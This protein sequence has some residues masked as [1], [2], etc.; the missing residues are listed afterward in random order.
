MNRFKYVLIAVLVLSIAGISWVFFSRSDSLD[1]RFSK[2]LIEYDSIK[3]LKPRLTNK[4]SYYECWAETAKDRL[5]KEQKQYFISYMA[6]N[7]VPKGSEQRKRQIISLTLLQSVSSCEQKYFVDQRTPESLTKKAIGDLTAGSETVRKIGFPEFG[8]VQIDVEALGT[9]DADRLYIEGPLKSDSYSF[10]VALLSVDEIYETEYETQ[11]KIVVVLQTRSQT[12][13]YFEKIFSTGTSEYAFTDVAEN[14]TC[15]DEPNVREGSRYTEDKGVGW[16]AREIPAD[17]GQVC[18]DEWFENRMPNT[19]SGSENDS[20]NN[21][22][23][24]IDGETRPASEYD[25]DWIKKNSDV[26]FDI[27]H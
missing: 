17:L 20:G 19:D 1:S 15:P 4:D 10:T 9:L 13:C 14:D 7:E 24:I 12:R 22:Y 3:D 6:T 21:Q 18:P 5:T 26:K 11:R 8:G 2:A 25:V 23:F 16:G 27:V